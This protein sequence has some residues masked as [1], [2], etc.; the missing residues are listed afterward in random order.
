MQANQSID[1]Q[2]KLLGRYRLLHMLGRGGMGEVWLGEDTQLRRRIA[3]KLLPV[4]QTTD[5]TYLQDFER[6]A[7]AAA[8]L[9]HPN[10]LPVHDF[11]KQQ[12]SEN[13][14]VTY[15]ILP[16][17]NDGSLRDRV[18]AV[19]GPLPPNET[20][21]YLR[22]A[23]QAID[24]AHSRNV[25]H[26]DIKP[27]NMLLQQGWLFL[28]DFGIA[29]L[30]TGMTQQNRTHAGAGTPEYM[31]PE[32]V[33]GKAEFASDRYS[34]AIVAYQLCTGQLPFR[35]DTPYATL[36]KQMTEM[37]PSPK[38]LNAGLPSGVERAIL[39]GLR[40]QPQERPPTC[41]ALVEAIEQGARGTTSNTATST[42]P[43]ATELAP[44]SKRQPGNVQPPVPGGLYP[45]QTTPQPASQQLPPGQPAFG[46]QI[47][48]PPVGYGP[49]SYPTN[50]YM[51]PS[52][53]EKTPQTASTER[54]LPRR[55]ILIGGSVAALAVVGGAG[56]LAYLHFAHANTAG[57][58]RSSA[59]MTPTPVSGPRKLVKGTPVLSLTGHTAS[60]NVLVWDPSGRYIASA[61]ADEHIKLWD[62]ASTLA[63]SAGGLQTISTSLR[64]WKIP[65]TVNGVDF[66]ANPNTLCWSN[67]GRTIGVVT[68]DSN[69]HLLNITSDTATPDAYH[70][71]S[72][73][74]SFNLPSYNVI[75]WSPKASIF[76]TNA[77]FLLHSQLQVDIWQPGK[78]TRPARTVLYKDNNTLTPLSSIDVLS[79]SPD[80][81]LLAG[82]TDFGPIVLWDTATGAIKRTLQ[83]PD[84]PTPKD[85]NGIINNECMEWSPAN[86]HLL[87]TSDVDIANIWDAYQNRLLL[88][89]QLNEP[90]FTKDHDSY[91]V[92]GLSWAPNGKYL[93]MCY[94]RSPKIYI[95]DVQTMGVTPGTTRQELFSFPDTP[96]NTAAITDVSWSPNGRYIAASSADNTIIVWKVDAD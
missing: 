16:Y 78:K 13:S 71:N 30:L 90:V 64:D 66:V 6:E 74:N 36:M 84:R 87:A 49:P 8:T 29:K 45:V 81:S 56:T 80:G 32:Q 27:A 88:N 12:V 24:F 96:V 85:M 76:A 4:T 20:L 15:L 38:Q 94:P 44:W 42:D 61:S 18:R 83:L 59:T 57:S 41:M 22:Q 21:H 35:G 69:V 52:A 95:W 40:K 68:G 23:A 43:E 73:T 70:D 53:T 75:A 62:V 28:A 47:A 79:F 50:G 82:Y 55:A 37:P 48:R 65:T 58:P 10:I 77:D 31:A 63:H 9:E 1:W 33:Q 19:G 91:F 51:T 67:D 14:L 17:I 25:L 39:W 3:V 54:K 7:R 11:G 46:T 93:A 26:R 89:L 86:L 60:V 34:F 72:Q 2:N 5:T 92:W